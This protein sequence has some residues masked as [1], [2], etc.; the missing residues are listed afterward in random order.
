M[1][2]PAACWQVPALIIS[3]NS[4]YAHS[5][6]PSDDEKDDGGNQKRPDHYSR[7]IGSSSISWTFLESFILVTQVK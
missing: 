6:P 3:L 5:R 4:E 7:G 2:T 1:P